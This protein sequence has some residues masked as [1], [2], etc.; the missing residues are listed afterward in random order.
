MPVE[1][2]ADR[3]AFLSSDDFGAQA[4]YTP[5]G[6]AASDPIDGI[7]DN[8]QLDV[9]LGENAATSDSRPTFFCRSADI[10][11]GAAAGDAGDRLAIVDGDTFAVIDLQPDGQGM[12]LVTLG[13]A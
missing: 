6:G 5:A 4:V 2:A 1:S 9:V 13:A 12:T 7:F 3:A 11:A 10:P 8:P